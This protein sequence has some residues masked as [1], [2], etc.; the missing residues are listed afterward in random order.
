MAVFPVL[1]A[2][3]A[4]AGLQKGGLQGG[5]ISAGV[6]SLIV[7]LFP[8]FKLDPGQLFQT[9][10]EGIASGLVVIY[11]LF[12][13]LFLYRLEQA[14]G[15]LKVLALAIAR[16]SP[17]RDLQILILLLGLAPFI[18]SA[19][20]FGAGTVVIIPLLIALNIEPFKAAV[21]GSL[22]QVAVPWGA[23]AVGTILGAEISGLNPDLLGARTALLNAP[24]PFCYALLALYTTGGIKSTRRWW[25][26]ALAGATTLVT[27]EF[28]FSQVPGLEL[29]GVLAAALVLAVL[30]A[31]G[32][33]FSGEFRATKM[34]ETGWKLSPEP[35]ET[36]PGLLRAFAPYLVLTVMLLASRL[37]LP[38]RGWLQNN[39]LL[40]IPEVK[41]KLGLFYSPGFYVFAAS[42]LAVPLLGL[43]FAQ[44]KKASRLTWHQF[45]PGAIAILC[46]LVVAQIMRNSGMT[47]ALGKAASQIGPGYRLLA[48]WLG[49]LGGWLTGSNTGGNAMFALLQ[50]E[51][52]GRVGLPLDWLMA[53]QNA[54][55]SHATLA[56]PARTIL[57][58]SAAGLAGSEGRLLR[59]TGPVV[60]TGLAIITL[61][62][63]F[64]A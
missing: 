64:V 16:L 57:A 48:P 58:L 6:A 55:G 28:F 20:G 11:V 62:F 27:G 59:F 26:A 25:P 52:G 12:P 8:A 40:E 56:S 61:L 3:F 54:A 37:V 49:G 17:E 35:G 9:Y 13:G 15:G 32:R 50:I 19:S 53:A 63:L 1:V 21:L 47:L 51:T 33:L 41:L 36:T 4:L 7:L 22:S 18:E 24:L 34:V 10:G 46:F 60:L 45:Y 14:S 44:L 43:N 39:L 42:F 2:L 30:T 31:W 38:L 5:F 23:L 29:A